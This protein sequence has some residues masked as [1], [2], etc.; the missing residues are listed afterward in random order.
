MIELAAE[1]RLPSIWETDV[2]V[3]DGGVMSYGPNFPDMYRRSAGYIARILKGAKPSDLPVQQ[4]T[5]FELALNL[6]AANRLGV[7]IPPAVIA[8]ADEVIE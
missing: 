3:R 2:Y 4:P 5:K 8:R 1:Y 6:K 7:T